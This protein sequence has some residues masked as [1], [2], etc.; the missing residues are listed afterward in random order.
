MDRG[1]YS[2]RATVAKFEAALAEWT[3][4]RHVVGM[5]SGTNASVLLPRGVVCVRATRSSCVRHSASSRRRR[6]WCLPADGRW[7]PTSTR[8]P[9]RWGPVSMAETL[10][11]GPRMGMPV[12]LVRLMADRRRAGHGRAKRQDLR[13]VE[14]S[15]EALGLGPGREPRGGL[16]GFGRCCQLSASSKTLAWGA[17]QRANLLAASPSCSTTPASVR[18][19]GFPS[20]GPPAMPV[21]HPVSARP[22]W[23]QDT[24]RSGRA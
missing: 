6:R 16:L 24:R 15:A 1:K 11:G 17:A 4:A 20:S 21:Q 23:P 18:A 14:D 8:W 13:V 9:T 22:A 19:G 7:S 12:H 3:R 5:N 10:T 2:H